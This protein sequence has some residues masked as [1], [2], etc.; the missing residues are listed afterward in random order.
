[1]V[2]DLETRFIWPAR[3]TTRT[4][5]AKALDWKPD[6]F[7]RLV[8]GEEPEILEPVAPIRDEAETIAQELHRLV[9]E[10]VRRVRAAG[11]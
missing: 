11:R 8:R 7:E 1:V 4:R 5:W 2:G 3:R 10:L 9:D 6:A